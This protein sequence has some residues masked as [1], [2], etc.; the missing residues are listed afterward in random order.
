MTSSS[1]LHRESVTFSC[2]NSKAQKLLQHCHHQVLISGKNNKATLIC[3]SEKCTL[4]KRTKHSAFRRSN[5]QPSIEQ[6]STSWTRNRKSRLDR[7]TKT[8]QTPSPCETLRNSLGPES[9][10]RL[11][12]TRMSISSQLLLKCQKSKQVSWAMYATW[13]SEKSNRIKAAIKHVKRV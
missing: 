10:S 1:Q 6:L 12:I 9:A 5:L 7:S 3:N 4:Q 13:A 11:A 2:S 8:K